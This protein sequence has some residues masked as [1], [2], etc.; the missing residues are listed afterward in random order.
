MRPTPKIIQIRRYP[1]V[2][3][4]AFLAIGVSL[5]WW[6]KTDVS[7]LFMNAMVRRGELW[8][9]VTSILPHVNVLHLLFNIYWL[10]VFGSV[11]EH[12]YGHLKTVGLILLFAVIPNAFE[13]AFL[14]GGVGLS[15]VGYGLFGLLWVLSRRDP[16][17]SEA[18]DAKTVQ[19]F[20][21]WFFFC[22]VAT[23][24]GFMPVAN[25]AHGTGAVTGILVGLA[26]VDVQRRFEITAAISL[27]FLA[28]LWGSTLG[29]PGI[30]LSKTAGYE[31][32]HR[33]YE[34]LM[35]NQNQEAIRW[36]RDAVAY[37]SDDPVFWYNLA[38]AYERVGNHEG[39]ANAYL[40]AAGH[41]N[42]AAQYMVG[43]LYMNGGDGFPKDRRLA[44]AWYRKA[45]AQNNPEALNDLAWEYATSSD[46]AVH[47][48]TAALE[49]ASKVV[50]MEKDHP[51]PAYLDTLAEAYYAKREFQAAV[52][53]EKQAIAFTTNENKADFEESLKR[54]EFA[55]RVEKHFKLTAGGK[56]TETLPHTPNL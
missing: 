26:I 49:L 6:T 40:T 41:G 34:A 52:D 9:L 53:T 56:A 54:Y 11:V 42:A 48:P 36:L 1:I 2:G 8:R 43:S 45:A 22:I 17:F 7:P 14:Q 47:N 37:R 24:L 33:G 21:G 29:R 12:V 28:G 15:G 16:R 25:I 46:P 31:E 27:M 19:L 30:N 35:A 13:F 20:V 44:V 39:S 3:G 50:D 10:W 32:A 23:V 38:I 4:T 51:V 5:L 55:L 18:I